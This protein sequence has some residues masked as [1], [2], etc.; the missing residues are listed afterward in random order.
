VLDSTKVVSKHRAATGRETD[1][2]EALIIFSVI[3]LAYLLGVRRGRNTCR[4]S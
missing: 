1:M 3:F 2:S 4:C